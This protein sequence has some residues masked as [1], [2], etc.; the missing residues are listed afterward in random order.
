MNGEMTETS[1][2][3]A[4]FSEDEI[5]HLND[6]IFTLRLLSA[7]VVFV[8]TRSK[9]KYIYILPLHRI[10]VIVPYVY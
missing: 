5:R 6:M 4:C 9:V 8:G 10:I 2:G 3:D 1:R 7:G